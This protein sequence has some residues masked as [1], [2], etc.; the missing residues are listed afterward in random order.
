[1]LTQEQKERHF[2]ALR[3]ANALAQLHPC[4]VAG[5]SAR[6]ILRGEAPKD[7]DVWIINDDRVNDILG[8]LE[9]VREAY[10]QVGLDPEV[11]V[12]EILDHDGA[13]NGEV[14]RRTLEYVIRAEFDGV[15]FDIIKV[16]RPDDE[17][18]LCMDVLDGFDFPMNKFM[19]LP[20]G[21]IVGNGHLQ[22]TQR[23][24]RALLDGRLDYMQD[25]FPDLTFIN[26]N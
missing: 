18:V 25:K 15:P 2:R 16:E 26:L 6:D 12:H 19:F 17:H 4:I 22:E 8:A 14:E 7:Y 13:Y 5:G 11:T 20:D 3:F 24:T 23:A 9:E 1:M 10:C 21:N